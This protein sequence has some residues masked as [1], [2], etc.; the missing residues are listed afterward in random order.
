[1]ETPFGKDHSQIVCIYELLGTATLMF[2]VV[3]SGGNGLFIIATLWAILMIC[4]G[5]T[6]GHFNPAVST[7]VFVWRRKYAEDFGLYISI[8]VS[9]FIGA[10]VGCLLGLLMIGSFSDEWYAQNPYGS[11]P[12]KWV[13][14][15]APQNPLGEGYATQER[16]WS[17][18]VIQVWSTAIF[19]LII[20]INKSPKEVQPSQVPALQ[21]L[22]IAL[23]LYAMIH[24]A[25]RG[26][27]CMNPAVGLVGTVYSVSQLENVANEHYAYWWA[28]V[29]GPWVGGAVAGIVANVHIQSIEKLI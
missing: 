24:I 7:G 16:A 22:S 9:Q 23:A 8:M 4:G 2:A 11:V 17:T 26:G 13:P 3:M 5:I 28:Y 15:F 19:V 12:A 27:A 18:F 20:L 29:F 10:A 1:M 21:C 25:V 14:V 6:G